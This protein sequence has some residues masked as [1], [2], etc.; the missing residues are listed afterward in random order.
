MFTII[1]LSIE[2]IDQILNIH[3]Q[4][5]TACYVY[6]YLSICICIC[7]SISSAYRTSFRYIE[8]YMIQIIYDS[9]NLSSSISI[10]TIYQLYLQIYPL[11][12]FLLLLFPSTT[13]VQL[14]FQHLK[15]S[16]Q[17]LSIYIYT[18]YRSIAIMSN[19]N[20]NSLLYKHSQLHCYLNLYSYHSPHIVPIAI[21]YE[22]PDFDVSIARQKLRTEFQK[23]S[24]VN[25]TRVIDSL[26]LR[27]CCMC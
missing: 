19:L 4:N 14:Q 13:D 18:I 27:V 17:Q 8:Q 5:I 11:Y 2:L 21:L 9:N 1:Y 22:V 12:L 3:L 24:N 15:L 25:D 16:E 26:V 10:S 20:N 23:H 7:I 6:V